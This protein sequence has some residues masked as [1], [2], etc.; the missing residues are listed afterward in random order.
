[1]SSVLRIALVA[2]GKTDRSV[3]EAAVAALLNDRPFD[4]KLL[5]PEDPASTAP[6]GSPRPGGWSGV[7]RWCRESVGRAGRLGA[8]IVLTTYDVVILHLDADVAD[9]SYKKASICDAPDPSNLPCVRPCPPPNATTDALRTA[10]LC[11]A[12]ERD[13]PKRVVLCTPSKATETWVLTALYPDDPIVNGANFECRE[14]LDKLLQ[15]KP[16]SE[17]L[18]SSGKKLWERYEQRKDVIHSAWGRVRRLCTEAERF[19]CDFLAQT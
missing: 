4:L 9:S 1:M 8:D 17:R 13:I 19:S 10:L 7:Y 5:Q 15:A 2:E 14:E 6:F 12:G 3:V 11:W 16:E 18:V